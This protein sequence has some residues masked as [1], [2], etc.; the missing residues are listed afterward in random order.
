MKKIV[1]LLALV[2]FGYIF[3]QAPIIVPNG[4]FENWSDQNTPT[5][6][7]ELKIDLGFYALHT[8]KQSTDA[9][10]GNYSAEIETVDAVL[11]TLPG[12]LSLSPVN[13]DIG[14]F[15]L[16]FSH[17]GVPT[18]GRKVLSVS[19]KFKYIPATS[20]TMVIVV[21]C[22]KWNSSTQTRDT[23]DLS[24]FMYKF[25][26]SSFQSFQVNLNCVQTPDS[27]NIV[28]ISSAGYAPQKGTKLLVDEVKATVESGA[29]IE[30]IDL[31]TPIAYPNPVGDVL[32]LK[33]I[34]SEQWAIYDMFGKCVK[35]GF[36]IEQTSSIEVHDL[37]AGSYYLRI[38]D[39]SIPLIITK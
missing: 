13:F 14:T 15:S 23:I 24:Y 30:T 32:Y 25:S 5:N 31:I 10:A 11:F 33:N 16:T 20:D 12:I 37:P 29:G 38:N 36:F 4:G 3:A 39:T 28:F 35:Q 27:M 6:W 18:Q 1:T 7:N 22:T 8:V 26:T 34:S 19:G 9:Y 2:I 21:T 17:A